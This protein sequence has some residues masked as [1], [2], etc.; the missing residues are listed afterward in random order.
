MKCEEVQERLSEYI[1]Q[2]L[3]QEEKSAFEGHLSTCARCR[4]ESEALAQSIRAVS[5]LPQVEPPPGFSRKVMARIHEEQKPSFWSRLF[6]PLPVKIPIQAVSL[7]LVCGF[8]VF[9]YQK[10]LQPQRAIMQETFRS[11]LE[12]PEEKDRSDRFEMEEDELMRPS[13]SDGRETHYAAG[14]DLDRNLGPEA[15]ENLPASAPV[16][17]KSKE[18]V[19]KK[20]VAG[21]L[22]QDGKVEVMEKTDTVREQSSDA[23]KEQSDFADLQE[24][25]DVEMLDRV[26]GQRFRKERKA[27][28]AAVAPARV[29]E[30]IQTADVE[31]VFEPRNGPESLHEKLKVLIRQAGGEYI[32]AQAESEEPSQAHVPEPEVLWL[33][34][35]VAEYVR[36]KTELA[37]LGTIEMESGN[38]GLM[39]GVGAN[40]Y[41]PGPPPSLH[42]KL[43]IQQPDM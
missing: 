23:V 43:T 6:F 15:G 35:P 21:A 16:V 36:F 2:V 20:I 25:G 39:S 3:S 17:K 4:A 5:D 37:S 30:S 42:I 8:A 11:E 1:E 32:H 24:E 14:N 41:A 7:L 33:T 31:L 28:I 38:A 40:G 18:R 13:P 34:I 19:S 22:Q 10:T 9:V 26:G 27:E 29:G 12:T